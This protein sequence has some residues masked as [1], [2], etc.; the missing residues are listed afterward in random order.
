MSGNCSDFTG[1]VFYIRAPKQ[2]QLNR[3]DLPLKAV[4]EF[5]KKCR[6]IFS[7]LQYLLHLFYSEKQKIVACKRI[8]ISHI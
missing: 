3:D 5:A 7:C 8:T 1:I 4:M 6:K 2:R